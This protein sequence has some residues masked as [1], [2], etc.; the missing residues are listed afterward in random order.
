MRLVVGL[1]LLAHTSAGPWSD[2]PIG[3]S[4]LFAFSIGCGILILAGL[5]T[6]VVG[7]LVA[8]L[9][10]WQILS[11]TG[12]LLV[13]LLLGSMAAALAMLG[14]GWWSVDAHL[15]GWKRIETRLGKSVSKSH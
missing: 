14:P 1:A 8:L 5:W 4:F 10:A 12:D 13:A 2:A 9:K 3:T 6:P 7:S 11:L 15:F